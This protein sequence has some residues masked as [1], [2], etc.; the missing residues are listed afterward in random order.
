VFH[1]SLPILL[2]GGIDPGP[3]FQP[4]KSLLVIFDL[5]LVDADKIVP[6]VFSDDLELMDNFVF[7]LLHLGVHGFLET[8]DPLL[9]LPV[10]AA[11]L[12]HEPLNVLFGRRHTFVIIHAIESIK[13]GDGRKAEARVSLPENADVTALT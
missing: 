1:R 3:M 8:V 6:E 13:A 4:R 9:G 11:D 12:L 7:P 10:K 2:S 5:D